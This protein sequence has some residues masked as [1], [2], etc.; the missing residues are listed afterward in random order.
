MIAVLSVFALAAST[1]APPSA[2]APALCSSAPA[3]V[4][5]VNLAGGVTAKATCRADCGMFDADVSCEYVS[6]CT[7]VDESCPGQQGH[8]ICDSVVKWCPPCCTNGH[9]RNVTTGPTCS[10]DDG[11]STPKDHYKCVNN[12]WE[13]QF[14]FCGGPFCPVWQ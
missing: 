7:A 8:V 13:Y 11:Q 5:Q 6:S 12:Q 3:Q 9:I 10:C 14:S 1:L 4:E 2:P